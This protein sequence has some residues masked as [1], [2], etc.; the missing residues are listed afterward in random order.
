MAG[1]SVVETSEQWGPIGVVTLTCTADDTD[2]SFPATDL[3]AKL[4]GFIVALEANP[5]ATGPTNLYDLVLNDGDGIDVLLGLGANLLIATSEKKLAAALED[6]PVSV[7][8]TLTFTLTNNSVN[9]AVTV[10]KIY[11]KGQIR[12]SG[13]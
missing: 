12:H 7:G 6:M 4:S 3:L 8:D 10:I 1:S 13:Q 9:D 2:G 11:V 5:G